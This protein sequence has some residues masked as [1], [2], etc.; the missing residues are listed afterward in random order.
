MAGAGPTGLGEILC[1]VNNNLK[2]SKA[3]GVHEIVPRILIENAD[4]LSQP[5]ENIYRESLKTG[6]VPSEWKRANVTPVY[7]KGPENYHAFIGW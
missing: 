2:V 1:N 6:V 5:L 4:Y 3:P 7:R